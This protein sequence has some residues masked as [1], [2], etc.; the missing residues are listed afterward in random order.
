LS[1]VENKIE[2]GTTEECR[3]PLKQIFNNTVIEKDAT[4][5]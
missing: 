1:I 3:S 5:D 2:L 4:E